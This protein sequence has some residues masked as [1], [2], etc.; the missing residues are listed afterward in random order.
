MCRVVHTCR[1]FKG[2]VA[3][4]SSHEADVAH[5]PVACSEA[6][7][8]QLLADIAL[9]NEFP[10][11]SEVGDNMSASGDVDLDELYEDDKED[12]DD[13]EMLQFDAGS[14]VALPA[15][16]VAAQALELERISAGAVA[17]ES[18]PL[19]NQ[20]ADPSAKR[21]WSHHERS[22]NWHGFQ[23]TYTP[24]SMRPPAGQWFIKC[25][26]H[27][28]NSTTACTKSV[29][30]KTAEEIAVLERG[31]MLW[32]LAAPTF[33]RKRDHA[34]LN[35]RHLLRDIGGDIATDALEARAS[36]LPD[37][38]QVPATDGQCMWVALDSFAFLCPVSLAHSKDCSEEAMSI[39]HPKV[40][41]L[42]YLGDLDKIQE[43]R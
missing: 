29:T 42:T 20:V 14:D 33:T 6:N 2:C 16:I 37:P 18:T 9:D 34:A 7:S 32:A 26:Y 8:V 39:F 25:P 38:P 3:F 41:V 30:M 43:E 35:P 5:C 11:Q 4:Q 23:I 27:R 1:L 31:I 40:N 19:T 17:E 10:K 13:L 12:V 24:A 21:G 22:H 15:H 36:A 28:L